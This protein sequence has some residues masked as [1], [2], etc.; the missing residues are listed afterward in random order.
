MSFLCVA[1]ST[2]ITAMHFEILTNML[3]PLQYVQIS[4]GRGT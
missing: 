3:E 4:D 2:F 1:M